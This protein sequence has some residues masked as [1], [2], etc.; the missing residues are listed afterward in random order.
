[1]SFISDFFK[2][3]LTRSEDFEDV[4]ISDIEVPSGV[5]KLE[6]SLS[7]NGGSKK[8][9]KGSGGSNVVERAEVGNLEKPKEGEH[10]KESEER[11]EMER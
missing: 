4:D 3:L 5:K 1:M 2:G 7:D 6:D 8:S 10:S 9:G 11:D